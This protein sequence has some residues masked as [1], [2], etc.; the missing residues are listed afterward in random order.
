MPISPQITI[1]PE[2]I[3]FKSFTISAV[4][5]TA[6]TATYTATGHTLST[7]NIVTITGLAPDGYNGTYTIT[8][9]AT[10]TFTVANTTNTALTDQAGNVYWADATEYEYT[11]GQT[12]AYVTDNLDVNDLISTNAEVALALSTAQTAQTNAA[13]AQSTANTALSNAATAYN[14]AVASLQPSAN[15]IVNASNQITAING[16]GITVYS[17]ASAT[18]GARVVLNSLGLAGFNSSGTATFSISATTGA[19]VFSGSV[20]GST[21]TGGSLNIAG[22]CIIDSSGL[23]TA[24]GATID[25]TVNAKSGYFGTATNGWSI[26]STGLVG[27]G[28]GTIVATSGTKTLTI[29]ASGPSISL[30]DSSSGY[31]TSGITLTSS[32][33]TG[34]YGAQQVALGGISANIDFGG[35]GNLGSS[36]GNIV[37]QSGG[38]SQLILRPGAG[39]GSTT[40][41]VVVEGHMNIPVYSFSNGNFS[42]SSTDQSE[43]TYLS[44]SGAIIARRSNQIPFFAHRFSTSGTSEMIRLVYNGADAGGITTTSGGVPAFRNASDYRLKSNIQ[45]F[46]SSSDIIKQIKLRS[47]EFIKEPGKQQVGFVAHEL[48]QVLPDLVM[49]EKDAVDEN[50]DPLYQSVLAT[51]LIPYLAGALKDAL[52]RIEALE[53]K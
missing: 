38:S 51:S 4:T 45:D 44:A 28:A 36:S 7:G 17:G 27:L 26:G 21:I 22:N 3:V 35:Y 1:T 32:G 10:N 52:L 18:T 31:L 11:G 25:G 8:G 13:T 14:A 46:E 19:A 24:T 42:S 9:T 50:G 49:G 47:Y 6:S 12:V 30:N 40:Y 33:V 41:D 29:S 39:L 20:T 43:G 15:T 37:L 16:N 34:A 23:L 53:G 48:A 5:Y 2:D